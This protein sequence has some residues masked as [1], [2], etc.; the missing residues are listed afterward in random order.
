MRYTVSGDANL[1][2]VANALDFNAVAINF[3]GNYVLHSIVN[4]GLVGAKV[5]DRAGEVGGVN[6]PFSVPHFR[7]TNTV[8]Y[9]LGPLSV[10]GQVRFIGR[11]KYDNTFT[12]LLINNNRIDSQ[13]YADFSF[14]YKVKNSWEV[15]GVMNNAFNHAPPIDPSGF[16]SMTNPIYYDM[17]G[18][19]FRLGVRFKH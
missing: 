5:V 7:F 4:T 2:G 14:N 11:G 12:P 10:S 17:V 18:R 8:T 13:T 3:G 6:N 9:D 19:T 15:F 1:D 16:T